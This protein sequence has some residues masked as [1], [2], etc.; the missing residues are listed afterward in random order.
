MSFAPT[1][2]PTL[3]PTLPLNDGCVMPQLGLGL[4]QI[5]RPETAAL[6]RQAV[7]FGYRLF[8]GA[9][10]YG[11]EAEMGEGVRSAGVPRDEIFVTTKI[12]NDHHGRARARRAVEESL[13]RIGLDR[14][15]LCLI[16]W[17]CP[18]NDLYVETWQTLIEMR[19]EG[20]LS[21]IGVSNFEP[22]HLDRIIGETG[23]TPVLNQIELHPRM[24]QEAMRKANAERGIVTQSW[25]PLG[26]GAAFDAPEIRAIAERLGCSPA[27]VILRWHL[28]LGLSAIPRST[29]P[30]H[31]EANFGALGIELTEDDMAAIGSLEAGRRIGPSPDSMT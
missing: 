25:T 12:W 16:H 4:Y 3:A 17:P 13:A 24:Q 20:H 14:I 1:K 18:A 31:V 10:M 8:D 2:A 30:A 19:E 7:G 23:V 29:K 11:N 28:Q 5:P 9:A 6:I 22:D 15:D 27:Q 21:S 26:R